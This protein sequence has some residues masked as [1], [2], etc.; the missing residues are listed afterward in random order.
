MN[1]AEDAD[2][3]VE[4]GI[5]TI[6]LGTTAVFYNGLDPFTITANIMDKDSTGI[7]ISTSA[8]TA[9]EGGSNGTY[10]VK[11]NTE[12]THDVTVTVTESSDQISVDKT[13]LT[14]T[15][16]N[17]NSAQVV[18][19][20]AVNDDVDENNETATITHSA[21][22]TNTDYTISSVGDVTVTVV[23]N[24]TRGLILSRTSFTLS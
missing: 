6:T 13:S 9:T 5:I 7:D 2:G 4:A 1:V 17:W 14:F 16:A 22:S 15:M 24:D 18:T 10:N 11:R 12:P 23:D 21:S 3:N 20:T 19:I 8:V